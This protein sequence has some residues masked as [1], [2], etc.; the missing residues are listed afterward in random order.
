MSKIRSLKAARPCL[1]TSD[2]ISEKLLSEVQEGKYTHILVGPE[3]AISP[4]FSRVCTT[5]EFQRRV[6]LVAVD[7]AHLV[8]Q[9]GSEFRPAYAQLSLLRSRLPLNTPWFACSATLDA[10]TLKELKQSVSFTE[11][12]QLI[13]TS[14]DRPEVC[15]IVEKIKPK[16]VKSFEALY[17]ILNDSVD[18]KGQLTPHRIPKTVVFIDSKHN[19]QRALP[20]LRTWLCNK[21]NLYSAQAVR[22]IISSYFHNT[23]EFDKKQV[24]DEFRKPDSK[25]RI[26]LSTKSL[27][28]GIDILDI[29]YIV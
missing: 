17:F 7:E 21:S 4:A 22:T 2:T 18:D 25:I 11:D 10:A 19:I 26:I 14:I 28:L 16:K 12:L 13:R 5:P 23:A 15:Y 9:W 27:G 1:I 8:Q 24:Y 29:Y 6:A 3:L 20:Q